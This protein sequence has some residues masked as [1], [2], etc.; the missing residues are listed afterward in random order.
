MDTYNI[1][2]DPRRK[3]ISLNGKIYYA[4][5]N[6]KARN[7]MIKDPEAPPE[8]NKNWYVMGCSN[9]YF[10][11]EGEDIGL[12][13]L[14]RAG[15]YTERHIYL[16]AWKNKKLLWLVLNLEQINKICSYHYELSK[17]DLA[18]AC[19]GAVLFQMGEEAFYGLSLE[20]VHGS[21]PEQTEDFPSFKEWRK[22]LKTAIREQ[23]MG[24]PVGSCMD[25]RL[26]NLKYS[27]DGKKLFYLDIE[28]G[29]LPKEL[30]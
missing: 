5:Q 24:F 9:I 11:T 26:A 23:K 10:Y 3:T 19:F 14:T 2:L 30:R 17:K 1:S 29:H 28:Y 13:I 15:R 22:K 12:K 20:H 25:T 8:E 7:W 21:S 27:K 4:A 16:T 18:P 6:E